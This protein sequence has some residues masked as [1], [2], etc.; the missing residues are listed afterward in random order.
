M[1]LA[2][3]ISQA[4]FF[5]R[6]CQKTLAFL[7]TA[8]CA[9]LVAVFTSPQLACAT[10]VRMETTLGTIDIQLYDEEAP[11]TVANFLLYAGL[12]MY[13][14]NGV[15]PTTGFIHRSIPGFIVQGGGYTYEYMI[16]QYVYNH[17]TENLPIPN[18]FSLSRSNVRGTIAMA[19]IDGYPDSAT[20]EWFFNLS[21]DNAQNLDYQNGGF[22]VF[23][24]VL[25]KG[26]GTGMTVVDA[27]AELEV[28]Q[29][30]YVNNAWDPA[31]TAY[32]QAFTD[33]P[34]MD[35]S[36]IDFNSPSGL[37]P[38]NLVRITRIPNVTA[39][40]VPSGSRWAVFT[41]D[42]DMT[43]NFFGSVDSFF[44]STD[45]SISESLLEK[46]TVPPN[47]SVHFNNGIFMLRVAGAMGTT[48]R[49]LVLYDHA[50]TRPDRYYAYGRTPDNN[51]EHW[52]DFS[53]DGK[54]G[55]EIRND[56]IIL[57]FIDGKRGDND[58]FENG[59]IEH[60]GAQA[61]VTSDASPQ[62]GGCSIVSTPTGTVLAGD[63]AL[64]TVFLIALGIARKR[65]FQS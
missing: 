58:L 55:A 62:A 28:C 37:Q 33:L 21:D 46:F 61:V 65:T 34:V 35:L 2:Q 53:F 44:G 7:L 22:T 56:R 6:P 51:A 25:D 1:I 18:E 63:W 48:G 31:C 19:K 41:A 4:V 13:S 59:A 36:L 49:S 12:G 47:T 15:I 43:F 38:D 16:T 40:R 39:M 57:H 45:S 27:I 60:I 24:Y 64:V 30:R 32:N 9:V 54:T 20:S 26:P 5:R 52:Y 17:I 14:T 10:V 3:V 50:D 8:V 29:P 11:K 23:G 42:A